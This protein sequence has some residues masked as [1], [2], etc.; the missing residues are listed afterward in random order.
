MSVRCVIGEVLKRYALVP[1]S[2][3]MCKRR[4]YADLY[5][6]G[7]LYLRR[8]YIFRSNFCAILIHQFFR[9]DDETIHCHPWNNFTLLLAGAYREIGADGLERSYLPGSFRFRQAEIFHRISYVESGVTWSLFIVGRRKRNWG[10]LRDY[11]WEHVPTRL[12]AGLV[13]NLFP[14]S[15]D[16]NST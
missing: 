4:S 15:N 13:G 3:W 6:E 14:K 9:P 5:L 1:F 7:E 2:K 11:R 8:Y 12:D 10:K 16:Q